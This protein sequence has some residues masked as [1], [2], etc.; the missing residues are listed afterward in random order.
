MSS[1]VTT[2]RSASAQSLSR[3]R[4]VP[5]AASI[6]HGRLPRRREHRWCCSAPRRDCTA[7]VATR[8]HGATATSGGRAVGSPTPASR[9]L[10][11]GCG[12]RWRPKP[13]RPVTRTSRASPRSWTR[14]ARSW[15]ACP[16]G[17]R[18]HSWSTSLWVGCAHGHRGAQQR[19]RSRYELFVDGEFRGFADY[20]D[21]GRRDRLPAH[22]HR[23]AVPRQRPRRGAGAR[24]RSTMSAAAAAR[25][26]PVAGTSPSSSTTIRSTGTSSPPE[27]AT[28]LRTPGRLW[29]YGPHNRTNIRAG[30]Q[31]SSGE[32]GRPIGLGNVMTPLSSTASLKGRRPSSSASPSSSKTR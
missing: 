21:T 7:G 15:P 9:R 29:A 23:A 14:T 27:A 4:S 5:R 17:S 30:G 22:R 10:A 32:K 13:G 3:S 18:G 8:P 25:S 2:S 26:S 31:G 6:V 24:R 1:P 20:R 19:G 12:W 16:I 28:N 11:T